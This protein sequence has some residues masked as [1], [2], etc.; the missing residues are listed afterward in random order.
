MRR[1][2][3]L[4][5][6]RDFASLLVVR[7]TEK[8][9]VRVKPLLDVSILRWRLDR[10]RGLRSGVRPTAAR[11][12][13]NRANLHVMVADHLARETNAGERAALQRSLLG[14]GRSLRLAIDELDPARRTPG[15]A[16]TCVQLIDTCIFFQRKDQTFVHRHLER[17]NTFNGQFRH[18]VVVG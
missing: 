16:A 9:D 1:M 17:A 12:S 8:E 13:A 15:V 5:C 18:R 14:F 7:S 3:K 6:L 2:D 11:Q 10:W 4:S